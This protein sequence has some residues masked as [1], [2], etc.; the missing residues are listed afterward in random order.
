MAKSSTGDSRR[1]EIAELVLERGFVRIDE[2][3]EHFKVTP[4]TI[5]RDLD[6]LNDRGVLSKVRSGAKATP[7]EEIERNVAFREHHMIDEKRAI[8]RAALEWLDSTGGASVIGIDDSTTGLAVVDSLEPGSDLTV[9]TNFHRAMERI[10]AIDG[11]RLIAV[12]GVYEPEYQSFNGAMAIEA[13][14]SIRMDVAFVSAASAWQDSV[15][16]PNQ[17]PLLTKRAM[18]RQAERSVL[19]LD[20]TKFTRRALH[21]QAAIS[22]F[23]V[24]V[25][26]SG[27][28]ARHLAQ[29]QDSAEQV[30]IAPPLE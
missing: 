28:A 16:Q 21:R 11:A 14:A 7:L 26:D 15:Y 17:G 3:A 30:I 9:V 18:L 25:V 1:S 19:M 10:V 23:D 2:L 20:H 8:A 24:V 12:G 13:V 27:I 5:H 29:L 4:M 22:E 6:D